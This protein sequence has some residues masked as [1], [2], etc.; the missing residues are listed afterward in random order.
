M[1][2]KTMNYPNDFYGKEPSAQAVNHDAMDRIAMRYP[3][4]FF[5]QILRKVRA[6]TPENAVMRYPGDFYYDISE[7]LE[8]QPCLTCVVGTGMR[9][10]GDFYHKCA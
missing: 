7:E 1:S 6:C 9:I 5:A 3:G 4:D 8:A 2:N 10:A